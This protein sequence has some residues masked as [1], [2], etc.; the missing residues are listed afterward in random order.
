[1]NKIR[2]NFLST[3]IIKLLKEWYRVFTSVF[4][5]CAVI[6]YKSFNS[7]IHSNQQGKAIAFTPVDIV[8]LKS[9]G[10]LQ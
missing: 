7:L 5:Q 3:Q 2:N 4:E 9:I 6:L 10:K 1:M 8:D